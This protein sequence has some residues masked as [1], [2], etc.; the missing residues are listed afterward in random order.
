MA[1][2]NRAKASASGATNGQVSVA[3]SETVIAK[4]N[5]SRTSLTVSNDGANTIYVYKGTGAALHKGIRLNKEGVPFVIND[6]T[7]EV[8]AIAETGAT[9]LCVSEV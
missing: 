8:T 3:T 6:W 1:L 2:S 5:R 9:V 4:A 7:G